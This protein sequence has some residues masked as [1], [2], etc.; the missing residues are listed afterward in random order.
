MSSGE[1]ESEDKNS[2][3]ARLETRGD[4]DGKLLIGCGQPRGVELLI[5]D[6]ESG[7]SLAEGEIGELW[8]AGPSV[9]AGYWRNPEHT[10]ATFKSHLADGRGP[11][12]RTGDLGFL[13][14]GE[15]FIAGRLKDLM[16]I[17]GK[18]HYPQDIERTVEGCHRAFRAKGC[19]SF[20][21]DECEE[22]WLGFG[23]HDGS[24]VLT[25][26]HDLVPTEGRRP[27]VGGPETAG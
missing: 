19:A 3:G 13:R 21:I 7:I 22:P 25:S 27:H 24:A 9:S 23:I 6:P 20:V 4:R 11:F 2:P 12:L 26:D 14:N 5:V 15:L 8:I 10:E 18:N 1:G 16:I 17:R